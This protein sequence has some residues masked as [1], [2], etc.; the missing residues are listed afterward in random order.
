[1]LTPFTS[2]FQLFLYCKD[3]TYWLTKDEKI[4]DTYLSEPRCTFMFTL[5]GYYNRFLGISRLYDKDL[6]NR[7]PKDLP[8]LFVS[9]EDDPV[10][11][12]GEEVKKSYQSLLDVGMKNLKIKLYPNDIHEILN[13]LDKEVVYN[14][15]YNWLVENG[16]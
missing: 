9:G 1:M 3:S 6:L 11:T 14:D 2:A 15:I 16:R 7:I 4:V 10:G 8:V 12:F 13:E 5:N